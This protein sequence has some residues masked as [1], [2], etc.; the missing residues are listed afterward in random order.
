M[1]WKL[2]KSLFS[3]VSCC[4]SIQKERHPREHDEHCVVGEE[5]KLNQKYYRHI[6][7][8]WWCRRK[9]KIVRKLNFS[10][11]KRMAHK[12]ESGNFPCDAAGGRKRAAQRTL[13]MLKQT[14][15]LFISNDLS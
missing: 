1:N 11:Y 7:K 5:W 15:K 2:M 4:F 12:L 10:T 9:N 8:S 3:P 13:A 6:D 14:H